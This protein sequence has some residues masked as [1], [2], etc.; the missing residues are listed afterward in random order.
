MAIIVRY[1]QNGGEYV[2]L[3]TGYGAWKS[4]HP[5]IFFGSFIPTEQDGAFPLAAICDFN[6]KVGWVRTEDLEVVSVDGASPAVLLGV[7]DEDD[8]AEEDEAV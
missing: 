5:S 8:E 1:K 7:E 6:G 4:T 2:L 3:G